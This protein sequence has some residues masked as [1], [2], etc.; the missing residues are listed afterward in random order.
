MFF[1]D[2]ASQD[3]VGMK[4]GRSN[5]P[6]ISTCSKLQ[7]FSSLSEEHV[8][9]AYGKPKVDGICHIGPNNLNGIYFKMGGVLDMWVSLF[10]DTVT[11]PF[12]LHHLLPSMALQW[13]FRRLW[14]P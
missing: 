6:S 12:V 7:S 8:L 5:L 3:L 1:V 9:A 14:H 10:D 2:P 4:K 11:H 13:L